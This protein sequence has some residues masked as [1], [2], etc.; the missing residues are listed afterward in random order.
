V[1]RGAPLRRRR[2]RGRL[3]ALI[4][5]PKQFEGWARD[6][7]TLP[8]TA[9]AERQQHEAAVAAA[10]GAQVQAMGLGFDACKVLAGWRARGLWVRAD[11]GGR[12]FAGPHVTLNEVDRGI[13][14][15]AS[16]RAALVAAL[17]DV[18]TIG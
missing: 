14:A 18:E 7:D 9:F 11:E 3:A 12:I 8:V 10:A 6:P 5:G 2:S 1:F 4:K 17:N 16:H 13:L 15:N